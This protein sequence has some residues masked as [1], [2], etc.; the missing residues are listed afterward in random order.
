MQ[1][2]LGKWRDDYDHVIVDSPPVIS[3][4]D[5]VLLSV[6]TDAV[7]LI[8]RSGQTTAAHVRRTRGLLQA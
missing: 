4:T 7:F 3:V 5:P 8:I 6:Q 2:L 1:D